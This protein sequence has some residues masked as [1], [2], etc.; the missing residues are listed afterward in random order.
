MELISAGWK[1]ATASAFGGAL[2]AEFIQASE[3]M[4]VLISQYVIM[5][6]MDYAFAAL[7]SV[8][9]GFI[10]FKIMDFWIIV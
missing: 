1:L 3:G 4:G 2:V 10:L 6:T 5:I 9:F 7:L 8:I